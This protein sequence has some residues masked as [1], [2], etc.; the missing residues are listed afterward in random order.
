MGIYAPASAFGWLDL[1]AAASERA[2]TLL[3]AF[4]EPGTLDPIGL[5]AVRDTFSNILAPGTSTIQTRLRYFILLPWIF[6]GIQRDRTSPAAFSARLRYDETR[7]IDCLRHLGPNQGVQGYT[8]G[9]ELQRMPSEAY[10]GGLGSWG[11]R[12]LD[13]SISEYGRS[14]ESFACSHADLDDDSN[15]VVRSRS[16]W[17]AMPPAPSSFLREEVGFDLTAEEAALLVDHIRRRHPRSLLAAAASFPELAAEAEQPWEVPSERLSPEL[18]EVLRHARC[19]S[20]LTVGPQVLYNLLLCRRAERE[21]RWD[22]QL[23][24]G[25]LADQVVAWVSLVEARHGEFAAWALELSEFWALLERHDKIPERTQQFVTDMV[26]RVVADPREFIEDPEVQGL[27]RDREIYLKGNRARLGT[28]SALENWN[29]QPFGA[30][31]V[32]RWPTAR[33]YLRDLSTGL[34][35]VT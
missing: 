30:Q 21:L 20:E 7:L 28:R 14:L 6:Q 26:T 35:A 19:V 16:M 12:R 4:E 22:T 17:A 15:P 24:Q 31:L 23:L 25:R 8:S 34:A 1:D 5:G 29:Q 32:Y 2:A 27:I 9:K 11:V 3:R 13:L 10:W 33:S 18:R